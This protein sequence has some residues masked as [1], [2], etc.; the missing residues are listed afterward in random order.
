MSM[1]TKHD[2]DPP[3]RPPPPGGTTKKPVS[4]SRPPPPNILAKRSV[5]SNA[6]Q[7]SFRSLQENEDDEEDLT[8]LTGKFDKDLEK[9]K[10]DS[11]PKLTTL[12]TPQTENKT[13]IT[14]PRSKSFEDDKTSLNVANLK[15]N[16]AEISAG[17]KDKIAKKWEEI[18]GP[19]ND[20]TVKIKNGT[21]TPVDSV[22]KKMH[23]VVDDAVAQQKDEAVAGSSN[24]EPE[25]EKQHQDK[26]TKQK[27][28]T[29][30][31]LP[32]A[33]LHYV[34]DKE[35]EAFQIIE[36][37]YQNEPSE[38][39]T[40]TPS[41]RSD[42]RQRKK[43]SKAK[44]ISEPPDS[45]VSM[46]S[47]LTKKSES[48]DNISDEQNDDKVKDSN[49]KPEEAEAAVFFDVKSEEIE[50]PITQST[51]DLST[52]TV[53]KE[54]KGTTEISRARRISIFIFGFII[55]TI[56]PLPSYFSGFVVG[57]VLTGSVWYVYVW[58]TKPPAMRIP[59]K[60][61]PLDELPP[62]VVPEMK[63]IKTV[64]GHYKVMI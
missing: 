16:F 28:P 62:L 33:K 53:T 61:I 41:M 36:D 42:L 26:T 63:N 24:P 64:D 22:E 34:D 21:S 2:S 7:K 13:L 12:L 19:E 45:P 48:Q 32:A 59:V 14:N 29:R 8:V 10:S 39:F 4:P 25:G 49:K 20:E 55:F 46:S 37:F 51:N 47:L 6:I 23:K 52:D 57:V 60:K 1:S 44:N 50:L 54:M 3:V 31:P 58:I 18:S 40:G 17:W 5:S 11:T 30:P 27:S 56:L 15:K 9:K 43:L 35:K 38:D